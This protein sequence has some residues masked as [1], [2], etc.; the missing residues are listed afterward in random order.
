[1]KIQLKKQKI[2]L[3]SVIIGLLIWVVVVNI[4]RYYG[5]EQTN[6]QTYSDALEKYND[7]YF[8]KAYYEFSQISRT[9]PIKQA[10]IYRQAQCAEH[11]EDNKTAIKKYKELTGFF[12]TSQLAL[13]AKYLMAQDYYQSKKYR[14]A[15]R[16]FSA[17][18]RWNSDSDYAFASEYYLGA[19]EALN[20][21]DIKNKRKFDKKFNKA[22]HY[23]RDYLKKAPDGRFSLYA[24]N[25]WVKMGKQLPNEDNVIIAN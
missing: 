12:P 6:I 2:A 16:N 8:Q 25:R 13:R 24:I 10:A 23:F 19:I 22:A 9:S 20:I 14:L 17:I 3:I 4:P 11:L 1:M 15:K 7:G 18:L 21:K 5:D